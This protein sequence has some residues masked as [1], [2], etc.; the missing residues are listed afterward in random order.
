VTPSDQENATGDL[1]RVTDSEVGAE[2]APW[3]DSVAV[4]FTGT[5]ALTYDLGQPESVRAIF[6]QADSNDTY[7]VS[8][9]LDG[10]PGTFRPIAEVPNAF[11]RGHGLRSRALE[12][13]PVSV[14][15]LRISAGSATARSR[16]RVCRVLR[17]SHAAPPV[18]K[19][20]SSGAAGSVP[21]GDSC[22]A[23]GTERA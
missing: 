5:G 3:D 12:F 23:R 21:P 16:S 11:S 15:Y 17:G 18:L 22:R 10:R 9:S 14:R 13:D 2:G 4:T 7:R 1:K 6:V 20:W 19:W 8:G